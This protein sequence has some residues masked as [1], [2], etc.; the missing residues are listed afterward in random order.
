MRFCQIDESELKKLNIKVVLMTA[1]EIEKEELIKRMV[2]HNNGM[3]RQYIDGNNNFILGYF[4]RYH[5]AHI[6]CKEQGSLRPGASMLTMESALK[7]INPDLIIMIGVAYGAN[8]INQSIGDVLVSESISS[9]DIVK[10]LPD[11]QVENRNILISPDIKIL[12]LIKNNYMDEIQFRIH[13]GILISGETLINDNDYKEKLIEIF[14]EDKENIIGGEME[15]IGLA[16]LLKSKNNHNW[17]VIKG[18]SDWADGGKDKNKE[19]NQR[20]A[21]KNALYVC[22]RTLVRTD[23]AKLFPSSTSVLKNQFKKARVFVNSYALFYYRNNALLGRGGLEKEIKNKTISIKKL[24]CDIKNTIPVFHTAGYQDVIELQKYLGCKNYELMNI[25]TPDNMVD[26]YNRKIGRNSLFPTGSFKAIVFDFGG[27]LSYK[28]ESNSTWELIWLELG[29]TTDQCAALHRKYRNDEIDHKEWCNQTAE[30]FRK[31]DFNKAILDKIASKIYL[32]D[33]VRDTFEIFKNEGIKIYICSGSVRYII[34]NIL[35][36][37]LLDYVEE[38][39]ANDFVFDKR[40]SLVSIHSAEYDF[41]MKAEFVKKIAQKNDYVPSDILFVGNSFNDQ[42]VHISK[43]K[44]LLVNPE[45]VD[46][47]NRKVFNF[48]IKEMK[49]LKEILKYAIP[50]KY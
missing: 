1:N 25:E 6:H 47:T 42:F 46:F 27:T 20:L 21:V 19:K 22:W 13:Y 28:K 33:G 50:E 24:E 7:I 32:I 35:G 26:F 40:G 23:L 16:S 43:A 9:T 2:P 49:D 45:N 3:L 10:R 4:G 39:S 31:K 15:G 12:N 44:T 30:Y 5:I 34:E 48:L 29:Y 38:I 36:E 18:I 14:K 8:K 41:E 37:E 11:N 17:V